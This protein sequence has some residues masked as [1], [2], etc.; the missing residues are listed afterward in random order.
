MGHVDV[1][2]RST[3]RGNQSV[4]K[5]MAILRTV[6]VHPGASVSAVARTANLPR[7]TAV[8]VIETLLAEGI[9][10]RPAGRGGL[11]LGPELARLGRLADVAELMAEAAREPMERLADELRESITL[12]VS[13]SDGSLEIVRQV[14][15]PRMLGLISWVGRPFALHASSSGKLAMAF[16][17][18][19]RLDE[20]LDRPLERHAA[21]TIVTATALRAELERIRIEDWSEIEDEL[22]DGLAAVSVPIRLQGAIAGSL[23]VSGPTSRLDAMTRRRSLPALRAAAVV[24]ERRTQEATQPA[25]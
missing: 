8:R 12:T 25:S 2:P 7:A 3:Q 20:F 11:R 23:N 16:W 15:G 18:S 17:A 22:E 6:A 24:I 19:Q 10:A 14:D 21:R 9:L 13:R 1:P 5:A 4:R